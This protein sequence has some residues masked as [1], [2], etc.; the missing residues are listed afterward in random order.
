MA[1]F[2]AE[3]STVRNAV[4]FSLHS[5][6]TLPGHSLRKVTEHIGNSVLPRLPFLG[7]KFDFHPIIKAVT[8]DGTHYRFSGFACRSFRTICRPDGQLLSQFP[9]TASHDMYHF[10]KLYSNPRYKPWSL[11][12]IPVLRKVCE[13]CIIFFAAIFNIESTSVGKWTF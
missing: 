7:R 8:V 3:A 4:I 10:Q 11:M 5:I 13:G 6:L 9:M 2:P 1:A 12:I